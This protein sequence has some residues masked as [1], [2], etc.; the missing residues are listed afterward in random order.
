M[1]TKFVGKHISYLHRYAR[2]YYDKELEPYGFGGAQ[3]RILMPLYKMDGINQGSLAQ[4]IKVDKTTIARTIKKL[5]DGGYIL[6]QVDEN[7]R[8]SYRIFL[9]EK[10]KSIEPEMMKIFTKWEENLLFKFDVDQR[11]EILKLIEIMHMNASD[12]VDDAS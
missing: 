4:I 8:R 11:K 12:I 6:R 2:R 9:T 5:I 10:G 1:Y 3:L 7:D